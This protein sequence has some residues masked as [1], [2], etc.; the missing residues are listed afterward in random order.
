MPSSCRRKCRIRPICNRMT[1]DRRTDRRRRLLVPCLPIDPLPF[2]V[3][4][5]PLA[6]NATSAY[7]FR[8]LLLSSPPALSAAP[9]QRLRY[10]S[11]LLRRVQERRDPPQGRPEVLPP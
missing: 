7:G 2:T 11:P 4:I 8:L 10:R 1:T 6:T 3:T 5:T 9:L